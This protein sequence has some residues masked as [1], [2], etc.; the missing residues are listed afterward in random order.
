MATPAV[1]ATWERHSKSVCACLQEESQ[2]ARTAR[3]DLEARLE[4]A[5]TRAKAAAA[6]AATAQERAT[7]AEQARDAAETARAAA[8][9]ERR[10]TQAQAQVGSHLVLH[11]IIWA[12]GFTS[13]TGCSE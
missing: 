3:E 12:H 7:E 11:Q 6:A 13:V 1:H 10:R 9:Q 5:T 8:E 4:A 2:E